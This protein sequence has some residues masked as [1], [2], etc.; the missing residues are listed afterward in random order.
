MHDYRSHLALMLAEDR[1]RDRRRE[2]DLDRQL[3]DV[4]RQPE[5]RQEARRRWR[6][7]DFVGFLML[8][9]RTR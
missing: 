9:R 6:V 3:E 1:I 5:P 4:R 8:D 2:A 7:A